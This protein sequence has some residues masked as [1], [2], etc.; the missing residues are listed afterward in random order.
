MEGEGLEAQQEVLNWANVADSDQ[1]NPFLQQGRCQQENGN[2]DL[3]SASG[4]DTSNWA[5]MQEQ[6]STRALTEEAA[7]CSKSEQ[8]AR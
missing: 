3:I 1:H 5:R 7:W 8:M 2:S 6:Q 4:Q